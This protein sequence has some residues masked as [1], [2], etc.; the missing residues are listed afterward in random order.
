MIKG[1]INHENA[2]GE[3]LKMSSYRIKAAG[4]HSGNLSAV[5]DK[6]IQVA[7]AKENKDVLVLVSQIN[8]AKDDDRIEQIFGE[9]MFDLLVKKRENIV[10]VGDVNFEVQPYSYLKNNT[11][12]AFGRTVVVLNPSTQDLDA[13]LQKG[14][15]TVDWIAV[16]MHLDGELDS[17]VQANQASDI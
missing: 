7:S 15:S 10:G 2:K 14:N 1:I 13:F 8:L 12:R 3:G 6:V 16:E 4:S 9:L 17:W 11:H 5:I